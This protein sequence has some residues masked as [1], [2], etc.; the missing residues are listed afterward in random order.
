MRQGTSCTIDAQTLLP[1][2]RPNGYFMFE[3]GVEVHYHEGQI[4]NLE[5]IPTF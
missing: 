1:Y 2:M 3:N 5:H 4:S